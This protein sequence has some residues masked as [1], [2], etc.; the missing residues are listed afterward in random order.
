MIMQKKEMMKQNNLT[1]TQISSVISLHKFM[2]SKKKTIA[3][4]ATG[5]YTFIAKL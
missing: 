1:W 2:S 4:K 3:K 5:T